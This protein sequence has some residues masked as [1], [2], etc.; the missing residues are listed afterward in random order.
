MRKI[1]I[2]GNFILLG[3]VLYAL[4]VQGLSKGSDRW[5]VIV[6]VIVPLLSLVALFRANESQGWFSLLMKRKA[7]EE[8]RKIDELSPKA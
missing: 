5:L 3:M 8:K 7:L 6:L 4:A 1:A 2:A